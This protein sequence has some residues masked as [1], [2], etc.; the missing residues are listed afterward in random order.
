MTRR[1]DIRQAVLAAL[2]G[3]IRFPRLAEIVATNM[4]IPIQPIE[5]ELRCMIQA[6]EVGQDENFNII[7]AK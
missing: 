5:W 2:D 6:R 3:P 1:D 4:R 7:R